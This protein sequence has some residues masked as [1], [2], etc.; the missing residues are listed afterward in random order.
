MKKT[1]LYALATIA[2]MSVPVAAAAPQV[3]IQS[4]QLS[5]GISGF[6][7]V[8]CRASVEATL[9][10]T[11]D[12]RVSLGKL[13]EFCNNPNGYAIRADYSP[14]LAQATLIV[15]G[16]NVPLD[17]TGSTEIVTSSKAAIANRQLELELPSG[18][19]PGTISFR[20]IPL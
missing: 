18:T 11:T 2:A 9:V 19:E 3:G 6:V 16:R 12:G 15:D 5:I 1:I 4:G 20:I 10:P 7:P 8:I 13:S 14:N 17:E